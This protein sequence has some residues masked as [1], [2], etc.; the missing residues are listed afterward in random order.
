MESPSSVP[1]VS[2]FASLATSPYSLSSSPPKWL[3]DL[4]KDD[5]DML[6]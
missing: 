6:Q 5:M 2:D 1:G 3:T 4:E